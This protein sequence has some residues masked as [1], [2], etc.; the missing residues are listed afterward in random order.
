[1]KKFY[2]LLASI[3]LFIGVVIACVN[4]S[5]EA[6]ELQGIQD[7]LLAKPM[8]KVT[9][10]HY[11]DGYVDAFTDELGV[12]HEAYQGDPSWVTINVSRN[13]LDAHKEH[14]KGMDKLDRDGDGYYPENECGIMG[15]KSM[16]DCDDTNDQIFPFSPV[17]EF[18]AV[19]SGYSVWDMKITT[20]DG[21]NFTGKAG[22]P[23]GAIDYTYYVDLTGTVENNV[24]HGMI[25]FGDPGVHDLH[26]TVGECGGVDYLEYKW[27][28]LQDISDNDGDKYFDNVDCDDTN[29][30]INPKATEICDG[31]DNDCDGEIDEGVT[32]SFEG[33]HIFHYFLET[34]NYPHRFEFSEIDINGEFIVL[35]YFPSEGDPNPQHNGIVLSGQIDEFGNFSTTN[36]YSSTWNLFGTFN[37]CEG[38]VLNSPWSTEP[39]T[40]D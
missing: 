9:I 14:N 15:D 12:Y 13:A 35:G 17:G 34:T 26:G 1:M 38:F 25:D 23:S 39:W 7:E 6:D 4:P 32:F 36:S 20:F 27:A 5:I 8:D 2:Y 24:F 11:D 31:I 10:C 16:Y 22:F 28:L 37:E 19:S 3:V 30:L 21:K 33:T 29:A 40:F 18:I